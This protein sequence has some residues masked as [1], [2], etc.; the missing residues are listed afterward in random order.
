MHVDFFNVNG[1][2]CVNIKNDS[3]IA[4]FGI[5]V[6]SGSNFETPELAGIAHF[7]EHMFFKGTK[8][9]T[10]RDINMEFAKLSVSNNAYTDNDNVFYH[11][12]CPK[13]NIKPVIDLTMDMFFNASI[14]EIEL[15]KEREVIKEEKRSYM[16]NPHYA[17]GDEIGDVFFTWE[18][19]HSGLGTFDTINSITRE[20]IIKYMEKH[21][22]TENVLFIC[23][24]DINTNDL[25]KYIG[26]NMPL[27]HP[28]LRKGK[29]NA[30]SDKLW[31]DVINKKDKIKHVY[32]RDNIQQ[33]SVSMLM[34]GINPTDPKYFEVRTVLNAL[35]NGMYS[36][37]FTKIREELGLCYSVGARSFSM[38]Y[39]HHTVHEIYGYT[40]PTQIELFIEESENILLDVKTN[41][42][43]QNI[44]EC[45]KADL[46]GTYCRTFE[47]SYGIT[48]RLLRPYMTG[49]TKILP[50]YISLIRNIK[51]KDCN[52]MVERICNQKYNWT[53]ML[54]SE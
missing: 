26:D 12:T 15:E 46:L 29:M 7:T 38:E 32:R 6:W 14:P 48:S 28:F 31:S 36:K 27:T 33:S 10:W 37:L 30:T 45:A 11:T 5:G 41:G 54:P 52:E 2:K 51:L 20:D 8:K 21:N 9:R 4:V 24:G 1:I 40:S 13:E 22:H 25:K 44:F 17:F 16:D 18:K 47:T 3:P 53:V 34:N 49:D 35:G 42:L 50:D 39:P 19:G 43:D 23:T